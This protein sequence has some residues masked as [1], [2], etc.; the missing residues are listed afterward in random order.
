MFSFGEFPSGI[1][2]DPFFNADN[3]RYSN[4]AGIGVIVGHEI[5]HGFD[6]QGRQYSQDGSFSDW[7]HSETKKKFLEKAQCIVEQYSN[8]T[9]EDVDLKVS[10]KILGLPAVEVSIPCPTFNENLITFTAKRRALAWR[11]HRRQR[12][13]QNSLSGA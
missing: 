3:P 1:L 5:S 2:Q 11:E 9:E 7:W 10:G 6:D 12:R 13:R 8:Y 4:Y